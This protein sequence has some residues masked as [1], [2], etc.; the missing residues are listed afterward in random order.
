[1]LPTSKTSCRR[2]NAIFARDF[3]NA[4]NLAEHLLELR[5][6]RRRYE[7]YLK[8]RREPFADSFLRLAEQNAVPSIVRL[9]RRLQGTIAAP[10]G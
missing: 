5:A 8:W 9:Y 1:M 3:A 10:Q 6:D 2:Q 7:E 4:A